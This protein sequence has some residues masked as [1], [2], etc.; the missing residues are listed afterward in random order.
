MLGLGWLSSFL[1]LWIKQPCSEGPSFPESKYTVDLPYGRSKR[2]PSLHTSTNNKDQGNDCCSFHLTHS[3][4]VTPDP[5]K[6]SSALPMVR[7]TR[8]SLKCLTWS[9]SWRFL[10]PPAYVTGILHHCANFS[11]SFSSMPFWRPSLS[12]AWIKNSEQ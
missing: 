6:T 1:V 11:T 3:S 9:R 10:P 12:A 7:S 8:P 4:N 2:N 5:P